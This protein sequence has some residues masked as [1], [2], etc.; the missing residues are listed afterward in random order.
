MISS[1]YECVGSRSYIEHFI[2][3]SHLILSTPDKVLKQIPKLPFYKW[4]TEAS[5]MK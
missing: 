2:L 5:E 1:V 3:I 4:E